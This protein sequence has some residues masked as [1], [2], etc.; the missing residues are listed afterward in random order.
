MHTR[1][2]NPSKWDLQQRIE[3]SCI[4]ISGCNNPS[5]WDLQQ[6]IVYKYLIIIYLGHF[7]RTNFEH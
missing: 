7:F 1:C 5:K 2:N 3:Q 4:T 6:H